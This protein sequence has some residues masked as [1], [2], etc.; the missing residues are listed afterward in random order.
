M[1][2]DEV[3]ASELGSTDVQEVPLETLEAS[4]CRWAGRIAAATCGWLVLL[5][6][7]DRRRGW[8][9]TGMQSCAHWLSWRC[10][11]GLR[12]ARAH[13]ATAR[14]LERLPAIRTAFAA[15]KL[16]FSK[17][18]AVC[19]VADAASEQLWLAH[20]CACTA[21]RLEKLV[22][23]HRQ[24]TDDPAVRRNERQL[25]WR[26]DEDGTVRFSARLSADDAAVVISAL[27]K[28]RES[29]R[30]TTPPGQD[31]SK[32]SASKASSSEG[33]V[34]DRRAD[35]DALVALAVGFLQRE[36][37]ALVRSLY[38][39]TAHIDASGLVDDDSPVAEGEPAE[40]AAAPEEDCPPAAGTAGNGQQGS[41]RTRGLGADGTAV[42][43]GW[44]L[45][46]SVVRRLGCDGLVRAMLTD[47]HGNPLRLGRRRRRA[48]RP[49][50]EAV[51][52]RDRGTCQFPGCGRT[53]WLEIHHLQDWRFHGKTDADDLMLLCTGHHKAIHD[54][55]LILNRA[56]DGEVTVVLPGGRCFTSIPEPLDE[57]SDL[58]GGLFA[59]TRDVAPDGL[60]ARD[61]GP[62]GIDDSLF[63]LLQSRAG[64]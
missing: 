42:L 8:A 51:Y 12:T 41:A 43:A 64:D 9:D 29:L 18:R 47:G 24:S 55:N 11:M 49:L 14:A 63:V 20:A 52:A 32:S 23:A 38:T 46:A 34:R 37:P 26:T 5:A 21:D 62:L 33:Q 50:A 6:A 30:S 2:L 56:V 27:Q 19:R 35:A 1:L 58:L 54:H 57:G 3:L 7:F 59:A 39:L 13:V 10:G 36:A 45:P 25:T 31:P 28:A 15:G 4:I 40:G 60:R 22:R 53:R 44:G 61:G 16:S 48:G 17:V